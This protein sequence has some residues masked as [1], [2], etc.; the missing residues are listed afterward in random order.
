MGPELDGARSQLAR[1]APSLVNAW[2]HLLFLFAL[3]LTAT[4]ADAAPGEPDPAL[5]LSGVAL[6]RALR[7]GGYVI[8]FRHADTGPASP[9]PGTV[10]LQRCE[11]QR[12]LNEN[13]RTQARQIGEQFRRLRIPFGEVLASEFCRCWQTA[14][15]AFGRFR[16]VNALT[17]VSRDPA[18][19][20][21]RV[22]SA[23]ALRGL[24]AARP[25][26][27]TNTILVS[28]GYNLFDAE[29]FLLGTQGEAAIYLPDGHGNYRLRARL[30]PEDWARL[31]SAAE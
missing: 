6:V 9:E 10:D 19:A 23:T 12:N 18:S 1:P 2:R 8:Y 30:E 7:E 28:H 16:K 29:G 4:L 11:T 25:R 27:S 3:C 13:G 20:E 5:E 21:Q 31:P 17:G 14:E 15:L 22:Q 24:L 26:A